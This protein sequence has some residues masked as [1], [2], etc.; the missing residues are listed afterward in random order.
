VE[1]DKEECCVTCAAPSTVLCSDDNCENE[2][3]LDHIYYWNDL[4]YCSCC[5]MEE[6]EGY[7]CQS[8]VEKV[9]KLIKRLVDEWHEGKGPEGGSLAEY[10]GFTQD[11]YKRWV[12]CP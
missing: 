1:A 2:M 12:E 6:W 10:L 5:S 7:V 8:M 11:E 4:P 3:C 9:E